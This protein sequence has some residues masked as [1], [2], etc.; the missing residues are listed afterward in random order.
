MLVLI[1]DD[2]PDDRELFCE[3][4]R[5]IGDKIK[6]I[7]ARDGM[8]GL[9]IL[10]ELTIL[11]DY[12]FL[13]RNMPRMDGIECLSE[14]RKTPAFASIIVTIYSTAAFPDEVTEYKSL[15]ATF[16]AKPTNYTEFINGLRKI[17]FKKDKIG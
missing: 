10:H 7:E 2:D 3:A 14:I 6:C 4:M 17:L 9:E 8:E 12:I 16:M 13:D 11:P 5:V 15:G 1:I